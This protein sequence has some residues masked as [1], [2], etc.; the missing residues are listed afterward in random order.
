MILTKGS[1]S[2]NYKNTII[3]NRA[4]NR[5]TTSRKG[6][7]VRPLPNKGLGEGLLELFTPRPT[8]PRVLA[9]L[10]RAGRRAIRLWKKWEGEGKGRKSV[11]TSKG[12]K[13][14]E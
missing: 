2:K 9:S 6:K 1:T 8:T 12:A 14:L 4:C 3:K 10:E 13:S 11:G 7:K 5:H